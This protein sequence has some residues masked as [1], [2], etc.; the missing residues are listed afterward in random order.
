MNQIYKLFII[1]LVKNKRHKKIQNY[2]PI[3]IA[4][5]FVPLRFR[6]VVQ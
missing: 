3:S 1:N 4:F 6:N 5:N 2:K